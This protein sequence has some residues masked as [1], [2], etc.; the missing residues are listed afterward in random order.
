[1]KKIETVWVNVMTGKVRKTIL[2]VGDDYRWSAG[3]MVALVAAKTHTEVPSIQILE[4][5]GM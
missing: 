2:E 4:A 1:V 5:R 3:D